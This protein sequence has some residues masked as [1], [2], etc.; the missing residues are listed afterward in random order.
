[1]ESV[2]ALEARVKPSLLLRH[3]TTDLTKVNAGLPMSAED[4]GDSR[5]AHYANESS[6]EPNHKP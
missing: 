1:M 2:S 4:F 5:V 6:S 3:R